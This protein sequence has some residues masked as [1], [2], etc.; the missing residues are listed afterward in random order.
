GL[1]L[2]R[3]L[4]MP[5][6]GWRIALVLTTLTVGTVITV[7]GWPPNLGPDLEGGL[8]LVYEVD[9]DQRENNQPLSREDMQKPLS[10]IM[11]RVNPDGLKE[12]TV[13]ISG[14]EQ[15]EVIVPRADVAEQQ[16]LVDK[17]S[18]L[19]TLEFRILANRRDHEALIRQAE[20]RPG[21]REVRDAD[22]NVVARW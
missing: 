2:A 11:L 6:H 3:A 4:R 12:V 16:R 9:T 21:L 7:M 5:D 8:Y 1:Y 10:A 17:I 22:G 15:V 18:R 13:R 19:G 14:D 20:S